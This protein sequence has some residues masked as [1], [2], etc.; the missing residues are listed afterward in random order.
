MPDR[1]GLSGM[2]FVLPSG[3]PW[4]MLPQE[5]GGG[6]GMTCWR[7]LRAW[8][9]AGVWDRWHRVLLDRLGPADQIDWRRAAV[10][11]ASV[12]AK[13]G[14]RDRPGSNASGQT[15]PEAPRCG[16]PRRSSGEPLP[17]ETNRQDSAVF[18][19]V[20]DAIPPIKQ[21]SGQRRQRHMKVRIARKGVDRSDRLGRHRWVVARTLAWLDQF[22]R[23]TIRNERRA[24]IH[25][26]VVSLGCAHICF[27][28]VQ[29][30]C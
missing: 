26:A 4:E 28:S 12:P 7:R 21:P 14:R 19:R 22:R 13:K 27:R 18:E 5:L 2:R 10:A 16:R 23:L 15:G 30:F 29:R 3:I 6:S 17:D 1:A 11:R 8:Q 25:A 9:D 20:L 24:D